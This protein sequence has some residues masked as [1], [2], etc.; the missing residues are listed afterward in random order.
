M[1]TAQE[2]LLT[3]DSEM[4]L[5]QG[6][7]F[8]KNSGSVLCLKNDSTTNVTDSL[9]SA[10]AVQTES[11]IT[12]ERNSA[13]NVLNSVF[14]D[15]FGA[16]KGPVVSVQSKGDNVMMK[17]SMTLYTINFLTNLLKLKVLSK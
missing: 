16:A 7:N 9:F 15:N 5:V 6:S 17:V 13:I 8:E 1:P 2:S 4:F 12:V 10:N 14:K 3:V 11:V